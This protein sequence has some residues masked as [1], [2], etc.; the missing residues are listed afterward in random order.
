MIF[1]KIIIMLLLI[2]YLIQFIGNQKKNIIIK[3]IMKYV[4]YQNNIQI[5]NIIIQVKNFG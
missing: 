4:Y 2:I 1:I 3:M 5:K